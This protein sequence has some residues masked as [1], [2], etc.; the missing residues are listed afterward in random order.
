[1]HSHYS[2]ALHAH[3]PYFHTLFVQYKL[4]CPN[5]WTWAVVLCSRYVLQHV[6]EETFGWTQGGFAT[7]FTV[8]ALPIL[9]LAAAWFAIFIVTCW[10]PRVYGF[11]WFDCTPNFAFLAFL[12]YAFTLPIIS[13][14]ISR[15]H[16]DCD[17]VIDKTLPYLL[18]IS[19][20]TSIALFMLSWFSTMRKTFTYS[21]LMGREIAAHSPT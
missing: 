18:E 11:V 17:L 16:F 1:M 9:F 6:D 13:P 12:S 7:W 14:D 15:T 10:G 2:H 8:Y 4:N 5:K 20:E 19:S 21:N 3:S